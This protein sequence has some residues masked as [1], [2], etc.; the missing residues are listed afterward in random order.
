[1]IARDA[2]LPRLSPRGIPNETLA[3]VV[4]SWVVS[5]C[6]IAARSM[7]G[8]AVSGSHWCQ[9]SCKLV[10][11]DT[12]GIPLTCAP[13]DENTV[14]VT[15]RI[16]Q[17]VSSDCSTSSCHVASATTCPSKAMSIADSRAPPTRRTPP[18]ASHASKVSTRRSSRKRTSMPK[19][20]DP[21]VSSPRQ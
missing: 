11:S 4:R 13:F 10:A 6:A 17:V 16:S 8:G 18:H 1:M 7:R 21:V 3:S 19:V 14:G 5:T 15:R 9:R 20:P 12:G 2:S